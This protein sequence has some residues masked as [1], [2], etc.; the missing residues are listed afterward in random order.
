MADKLK[1]GASLFP[2]NTATLQNV[3]PVECSTSMPEIAQP[4]RTR[5]MR[6]EK[7]KRGDYRR[8]SPKREERGG[9]IFVDNAFI[10][11]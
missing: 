8:Y 5:L 9:N 11:V 3:L 1:K 6:R 2:F 7:K 10:D 4:F